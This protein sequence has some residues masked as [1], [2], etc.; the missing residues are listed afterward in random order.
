MVGS[1]KDTVEEEV[2][3]RFDRRLRYLHGKALG[4][5]QHFGWKSLDILARIQY[6][7]INKFYFF[8]F[9]W[10]FYAL[11]VQLPMPGCLAL[12]AAILTQKFPGSV[13]LTC[14]EISATS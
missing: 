13:K 7:C 14:P 10:V 9:S 4:H 12:T 6:S 5:F 8:V 1:A 3:K 2:L 11:P